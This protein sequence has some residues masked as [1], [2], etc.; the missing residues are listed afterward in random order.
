M[1][2]S[3]LLDLLNGFA[4]TVDMFLSCN[5]SMIS[6]VNGDCGFILS[7]VHDSAAKDG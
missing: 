1:P 2:M 3:A 7:K 5:C 6:F 4:Q